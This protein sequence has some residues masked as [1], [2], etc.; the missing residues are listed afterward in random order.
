MLQDYRCNSQYEDYFH[1]ERGNREHTAFECVD[2]GSTRIELC[3]IRDLDNVS[4]FEAIYSDG[5][6]I[7]QARARTEKRILSFT[8][9]GLPS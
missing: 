6:R 1:S 3:S 5:A 9:M 2:T 4:N 8:F 7:A